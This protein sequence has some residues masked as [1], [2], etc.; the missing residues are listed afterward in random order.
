MKEGGPA[1][2]GSVLTFLN[3]TQEEGLRVYIQGEI[4]ENPVDHRDLTPAAA[5]E[6]M[7]SS[8]AQLLHM[9]DVQGTYSFY[10]HESG[11]VRKYNLT[12]KGNATKT[13]M[14]SLELVCVTGTEKTK[15]EIDV[16]RPK[17]F[18]GYWLSRFFSLWS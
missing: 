6:I 9:H 14:G 16:K 7:S 17:N 11:S 15:K 8:Y 4:A 3:T 2:L 1:D 10:A 13:S 12:C 18:I 5:H